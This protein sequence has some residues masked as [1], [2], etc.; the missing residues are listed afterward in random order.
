MSAKETE[1]GIGQKSLFGKQD[2]FTRKEYKSNRLIKNIRIIILYKL[3][4]KKHLKKHVIIIF[5]YH[6]NLLVESAATD[7]CERTRVS[8]KKLPSV[9]SVIFELYPL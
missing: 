8:D 4:T 3:L 6:V 1:E 5:V 7:S 2:H 9:H